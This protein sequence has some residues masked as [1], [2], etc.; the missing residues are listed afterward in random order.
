MYTVPFENQKQALKICVS[1]L[2]LKT[3]V[4]KRQIASH[5]PNCGQLEPERQYLASIYKFQEVTVSKGYRNLL[6]LDESYNFL[7][8][9]YLIPMRNGALVFSSC[10]PLG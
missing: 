4:V 1:Y 3:W 9:P 10:H 5:H 6:G 7:S 8:V 2:W